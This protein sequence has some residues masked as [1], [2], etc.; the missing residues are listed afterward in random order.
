MPRIQ[1]LK[2]TNLL[3]DTKYDLSRDI[4]ISAE[5]AFFGDSNLGG[6]GFC[7]FL[8][9]A[10]KT[11]TT[12]N[13]GSPGPGLGYAPSDN[14]VTY[15]NNNIFDGVENSLLG[16]GF[17]AVG[18]FAAPLGYTRSGNEITG[19]LRKPNAITLRNGDLG[20]KNY[21]LISSSDNLSSFGINLYQYY[22][23]SITPTPTNTLTTTPTNTV[24]P[25]C[26]KNN[27]LT[28]T[29]TYTPSITITNTPTKTRSLTLSPTIFT[30]STN[31]P[32]CTNTITRTP[33]Q[34]GYFPVRKA[35]RIVISDFGKTIQ[36][37]LRNSNDGNFIL[38]HEVGNITLSSPDNN[39]VKVGLSYCTGTLTSSLY[40]YNFNVNGTGIQNTPT[41]TATKFLTPT[42]SNSPTC[43]VTATVTKTTNAS[44]TLTPTQTPTVTYTNTIT[45]TS[46]VTPTT[47][48]TNTPTLTYTSTTTQTPTN[49]SSRTPTIS[50]SK[51]G[52]TS[53]PTPTPTHTSTPTY[54]STLNIDSNS[55]VIN[56]FTDTF[57]LASNAC[58]KF[59]F[60]SDYLEASDAAI[61]V[62]VLINNARRG[63]NNNQN[64]LLNYQSSDNPTGVTSNWHY[65][66]FQSFFFN[67]DV[68]TAQTVGGT[69]ENGQ[70][71]WMNIPFIEIN[72]DNK[73]PR[74]GVRSGIY[75]ALNSLVS[76]GSTLNESLIYID[77]K[78]NDNFIWNVAGLSED[79]KIPI[80]NSDTSNYYFNSFD[81]SVNPANILYDF[82]YITD[83]QNRQTFL[84]K[85][86]S[87]RIEPNNRYISVNVGQLNYT[88]SFCTELIRYWPT[89]VNSSGG[90]IERPGFWGARLTLF[91]NV[92]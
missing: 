31:T 52:V 33:T 56:S 6:E 75:Q 16:I 84:S 81:L 8:V 34:T 28:P 27:T 30:T 61:A 68:I 44:P 73:D 62:N 87:Y 85:T 26:T 51:P 38:V 41:P 59:V 13:N 9:D 88:F 90:N 37:Y 35:F 64:N 58:Y 79:Y 7:V 65:S 54:S 47:T 91:I 2:N 49:F 17:D 57:S 20:D 5:F 53:E 80:Y 67:G 24:S 89:V 83:Y 10:N 29:V 82:D 42:K 43:T 50:K 70:N 71:Y 1:N 46:F 32:T 45:P 12:I 14:K 77:K 69:A 76:T 23:G 63:F 40:L 74:K 18:N 72:N 66:K 39:Q 25:S 60:E 92:A 78:V 36:I 48:R 3:L 21:S 15:K 11:S 19:G 55:N 86:N 4:V 22:Y